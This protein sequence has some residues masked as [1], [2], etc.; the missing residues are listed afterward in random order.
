M[1]VR[2]RPVKDEFEFEVPDYIFKGYDELHAMYMFETYL[3]E[4]MMSAEWWEVN[5]NDKEDVRL[6][7]KRRRKG[8][9]RVEGEQQ[10]GN[11][12]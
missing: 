12:L 9:D 8:L 11:V 3:R 4:V 6:A 1:K 5:V 10:R 2:V 7:Y